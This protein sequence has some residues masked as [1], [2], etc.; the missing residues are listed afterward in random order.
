MRA[1]VAPLG[2]SPEADACALTACHTLGGAR[3]VT[4]W[5]RTPD[6]GGATPDF[7]LPHTHT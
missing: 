2:V 3:T 5:G 1:T 7:P 4:G 6:N